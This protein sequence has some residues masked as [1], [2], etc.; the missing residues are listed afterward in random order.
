VGITA[1][2]R[3]VPGRNACDRRHTYRIII[4]II[5]KIMTY[6]KP[7]KGQPTAA[8]NWV[9]TFRGP[10][11]ADEVKWPMADKFG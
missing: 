9:D 10:G 1:G 6:D 4:I 11:R 3:K 7:C 5:T 2:S 8:V